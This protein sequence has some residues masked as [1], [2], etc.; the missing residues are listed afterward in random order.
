MK[1]TQLGIALAFLSFVLFACQKDVCSNQYCFNS[2]TCIDGDCH[3]PEGYTGQHCEIITCS[4]SAII[5]TFTIIPDTCRLFYDEGCG[6]LTLQLATNCCD[7]I[8]NNHL[9]DY[10][11]MWEGPNGFMAYT[12]DIHQI[13][14][15][16]YHIR[17]FCLNNTT[18][19]WYWVK[20][21]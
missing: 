10:L 15:G 20:P 5:D 12:K 21:K 3:C 6:H 19:Y 9:P 18:D 7:T 8:P 16:W 4:S 2:G 1:K 11:Y 17:I 13:R 14:Y